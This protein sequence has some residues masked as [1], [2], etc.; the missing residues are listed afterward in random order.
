MRSAGDQGPFIALGV[1]ECR[2]IHLRDRAPTS[3]C[4]ESL[5]EILT[6]VSS[7][8]L[9]QAIDGNCIDF[10]QHYGY[11]PGCE[12][13]DERDLAWF[14][15]GIPHPLFNGVMRTDLSA[16][17]ANRRIDVMVEEFRRRRIPLEW[18]TLAGTRPADLG[19]R[20]QEKG[21]EHTLDVAG[22]A[23]DLGRLTDERLPAGL[24]I[25]VAKTGTD[26][27]SCLEI[28]LI[29]FEISDRFAPRLREIEEGLPTDQKARTRHYLGRMDGRPVATSEL[30]LAAGVAGIYF[31]GTLPEARGRGIARVLTLAALRDARDMGYRVGTLQATPEGLS[32]YRG[33]GFQELLKMGIYLKV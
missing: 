30:Y 20:L 27:E 24:T 5:T 33:L 14:V 19:R 16:H 25:D 10:F 28:A 11:G 2:R 32:V 26:L 15:T 17:E 4:G 1:S 31:V 7:D 21:F 9:I 3:V 12:L 29:T 22:M 6:D 18:T 23:M 8:A 13:H